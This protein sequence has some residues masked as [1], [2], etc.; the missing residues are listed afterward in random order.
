ML[1]IAPKRQFQI[2]QLLNYDAPEPNGYQTPQ[3]MDGINIDLHWLE[4][5]VIIESQILGNTVGVWYW[6]AK[7]TENEMVYDK[8]F[9]VSG[10]KVDYFYSDDPL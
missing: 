5:N 7:E 1:K 4:Q 8:L 2:V 9:G 6:D 10:Y 3:G